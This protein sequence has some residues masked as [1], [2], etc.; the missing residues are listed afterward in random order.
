MSM[1]TK[2]IQRMLGEMR[3]AG[4]STDEIARRARIARGPLF[5]FLQGDTKALS[6]EFDKIALLYAQVIG[7]QPPP[8]G[9]SAGT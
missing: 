2:Q 1:T 5:R 9:P 4:L 6:D 8:Q 3:Q 7:K